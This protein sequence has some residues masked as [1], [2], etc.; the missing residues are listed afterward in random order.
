M[1]SGALM[2]I[3]IISEFGFGKSVFSD[4]AMKSDQP[5]D[6][7]YS[8]ACKMHEVKLIVGLKVR[9]RITGPLKTSEQKG[10]GVQKKLNL[11]FRSRIINK[12]GIP[13]RMFP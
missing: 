3:S 12:L 6:I 8:S 4:F 7:S 11:A 1:I 13:S 10:I 5:T 9:A 2:N